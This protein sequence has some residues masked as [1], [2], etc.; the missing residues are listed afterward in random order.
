ME[1]YPIEKLSETYT[2]TSDFLIAF[3]N[4]LGESNLITPTQIKEIERYINVHYG[5]G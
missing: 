4:D 2:E 5:K 3:C 1:G